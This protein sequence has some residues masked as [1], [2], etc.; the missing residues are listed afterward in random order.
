M[1]FSLGLPVAKERRDKS[2]HVRWSAVE[3]GLVAP[4]RGG[5]I[6]RA[7]AQ[8]VPGSMAQGRQA[9]VIG[10]RAETSEPQETILGDRGS[11]KPPATG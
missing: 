10:A 2:G 6:V 3:I 9:Q 11:P 8:I 4:V 5:L 7:G 1:S